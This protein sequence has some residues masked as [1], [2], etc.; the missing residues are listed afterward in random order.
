MRKTAGNASLL[1]HVAGDRAGRRE[2]GYLPENHR[3]P[4]HL[5]GNSA[6]SY[7]GGLSNLSMAE[8]NRKRPELLERVGLAD[9]GKTS[10]RKYSKG[11]LQR[12]GL[13]QAMLHDPQLLILDEPTDGVDPVGR[14]EMRKVLQ[15]LKEDGR[16]IFINSHLLQEVELICDRA[17]ILVQ[18]TLRRVGMIEEITSR[19][20]PHFEF[21][22]GGPEQAIREAFVRGQNRRHDLFRERPLSRERDRPGPAGGKS[23]HRRTAQPAGRHLLPQPSAANARRCIY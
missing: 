16:T 2:V 4:R 23:L 19:E 10:V 15:T 21:K 9:W 6:L 11:M 17:A 8:V 20:Q 1:G 14:S 5:T 13:A 22:L 3:I 7:Y 18:G 12:L